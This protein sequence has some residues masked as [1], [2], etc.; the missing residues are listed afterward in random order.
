MNRWIEA[1]RQKL[2]ELIGFVPGDGA[3]L[4]AG[5]VLLAVLAA[6]VAV[7]L[8]RRRE[9]GGKGRFA[10]RPIRPVPRDE[11]AE[12]AAAL[13]VEVL[14]AL[15]AGGQDRAFKRAERI[16]EQGR[17]LFNAIE[18]L[19]RLSRG[20]SRSARAI[21]PALAALRRGDGEPAARLLGSLAGSMTAKETADTAAAALLRHQ[22][23]LAFL[24][25]PASASVPVRWAVKLAP[26]Q[27]LAW[28]LCAII[29]EEEGDHALAR[30]AC[31]TVLKLGGGSAGQ[32]LLAGAVG[33]LGEIHLACGDLDRAEEALRIALTHQAGLAR[34]ESMVRLYRCLAQVEMARGNWARSGEIVE[35]AIGLEG[36]LGHQVGQADL[37]LQAGLISQRR[38][39]L[40]TAFARWARARQ[41]FEEAGANEKVEALDRLIA[42]SFSGK[43]SYPGEAST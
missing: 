6:F 39:D 26:E 21:E 11:T 33:M 13:V 41:L 37:E 7:G 27:P 14:A 34:P 2:A 4:G 43:M 36:S 24:S 18:A 28:T 23:A 3:W 15:R 35:K 22:A 31:E 17:H 5:L 19:L 20:W 42:R 40:S 29:A 8:A 38:G 9:P 1:G 12:R 16:E 10:S 30:R 32:G 25:D